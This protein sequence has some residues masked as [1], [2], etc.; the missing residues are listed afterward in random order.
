[1]KQ[2]ELDSLQI[3]PSMLA[4]T[5]TSLVKPVLC[6]V[7]QSGKLFQPEHRLCFADGAGV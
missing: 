1:M 7:S 3:M 5:Q 4:T 6:R 2:A